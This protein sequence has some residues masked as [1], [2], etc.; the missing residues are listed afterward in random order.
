MPISSD[1]SDLISALSDAEAKFLIVGAYAVM[2][3]TEPR[4]TKDLDIWI[5]PTRANAGRV[6]TALRAFGAPVERI[7]KKDLATPGIIYQIGVEPVRVDL[8]TSISGLDFGP[9]YA[10]AVDAK[11]GDMRIKVLSLDD[12]IKAKQAA[13]RPQDKLDLVGLE[14]ARAESSA[15]NVRLLSAPCRR[16]HLTIATVSWRL[17]GSTTIDQQTFLSALQRVKRRCDIILCAGRAVRNA[18]SPSD[19]LVA[20]RGSPV[21]FER[22]DGRWC[23]AYHRDGEAVRSIVREKQ[24]LITGLQFN[25]SEPI[26]W[27]DNTELPGLKGNNPVAHRLESGQG[28]IYLDT[29]DVCLALFICG[30]NNALRRGRGPSVLRY[31]PANVTLPDDLRRRWVLLNPAHAPYGGGSQRGLT[32]V[33]PVGEVGPTL[34]NLVRSALHYA[35]GTVSPA[36]VIH[37]NNF[38]DRDPSAASVVFWGDFT[39]EPEPEPTDDNTHVVIYQLPL[40]NL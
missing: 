29:L 9:A 35:D 37:C 34:R 2:H 27:K 39:P 5:E 33:K 18:P 40:K 6:M 14:E 22:H 16:G 19:I 32:K 23:I 26:P 31:K 38:K 15:S 3:Y 30:E 28:L 4:Y 11:Y 36:A 12:I 20:S 13:G 1:F 25:S 7:S 24:E 10:N 17:D 8:I 21:L